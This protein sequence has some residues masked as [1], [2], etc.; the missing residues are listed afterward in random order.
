MNAILLKVFRVTDAIS[1]FKL[2]SVQRFQALFTVGVFF[3]V[4]GL[5]L[6][7]VAQVPG[8]PLTTGAGNAAPGGGNQC[9]QGFWFM[10]NLYS[11]IASAFTGFGG[12]GEN[13]C[14][15][16]NIVVIFSVLALVVMVLWGI[17]DHKLNDTPFQKA[18]SPFVGWIAGLVMIY[19]IIFVAFIGVGAGQRTAGT[20]VQP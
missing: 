7:A 15:V 2:T 18:F 5:P 11:F 6:N 8:G 10:S 16:V 12:V 3:G 19:T 20:G 17:G 4:C 14:Q 13:I 1:N 9:G